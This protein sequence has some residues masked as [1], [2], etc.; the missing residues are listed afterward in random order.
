MKLLRLAFA[1]HLQRY[2]ILLGMLVVLS[3]CGGGGVAYT[4]MEDDGSICVVNSAE[5][6]HCALG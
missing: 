2:C 1:K 5:L 3:A 4:D 6:D